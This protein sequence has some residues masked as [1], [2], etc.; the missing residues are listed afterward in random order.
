VR[1]CAGRSGGDAGVHGGGAH[2][3]GEAVAYAHAHREAADKDE[4][5]QEYR[6]IH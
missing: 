4:L 3:K 5:L 1:T 6:P 2:G